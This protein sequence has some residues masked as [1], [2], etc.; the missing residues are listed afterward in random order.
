MLA[1]VGGVCYDSSIQMK[2]I[3]MEI[4]EALTIRQK[5]SYLSGFST[6]EYFL[7]TEDDDLVANLI[8][9]WS[10]EK[11]LEYINENY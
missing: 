10:S 8:K 6:V 3:Q 9:G 2:G 5:L 7:L 4:W 1:F 11:A